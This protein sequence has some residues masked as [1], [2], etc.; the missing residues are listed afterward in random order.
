[1]VYKPYFLKLHLLQVLDADRIVSLGR[2]FDLTSVSI[3]TASADMLLDA[4]S[5]SEAP[6][7][8][9]LFALM[10]PIKISGTGHI[11]RLCLSCCR[12]KV[13][14]VSS[15]HQM[16]HIMLFSRVVLALWFLSCTA[17]IFSRSQSLTVM[18][19]ILRY[20]VINCRDTNIIKS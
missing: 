1:M 3:L 8:S 14:N 19:W 11:Q 12:L 15:L 7:W 18:A 13:S 10:A 16:F 6:A 17:Y 2:G 20:F 9:F 4:W 5:G